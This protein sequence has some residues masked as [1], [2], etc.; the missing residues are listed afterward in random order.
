MRDP[1]LQAALTT[2]KISRPAWLTRRAPKRSTMRELTM[3]EIAIVAAVPP[4][5][6]G[7]IR[8]P[9]N[10]RRPA[11]APNSRSRTPCRS[12]AR[13]PARNRSPG[14]KSPRCTCCAQGSP[15]RMFRRNSGCS[16]SGRRSPAQT[17]ITSAHQAEADEDPA[18]ARHFS[19]TTWPIARRDHRHGDEHRRD[20]REHLRHL[21]AFELVADDRAGQ[22]H[23]PGG[24]Q[25]PA[26]RATPSAGRSSARRRSAKP[27]TT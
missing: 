19:S 13:C 5:T 7:T 16:V 3:L 2:M 6:W 20:Q 26:A 12:P 9:R 8:P 4:N 21:V 17:I 22:H 23:Q 11:A 18:P 1:H 27:N 24:D 25:R 14:A 10:A 15:G